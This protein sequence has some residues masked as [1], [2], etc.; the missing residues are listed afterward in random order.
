LTISKRGIIILISTAEVKLHQSRSSSQ[1]RLGAQVSKNRST[2]DVER[3]LS[4]IRF[5][6]R[7]KLAELG[8]D[9]YFSIVDV[10]VEYVKSQIIAASSV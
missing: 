6:H 3:F 8:L 9:S 4:L 5:K 2:D 7:E 1:L 10:H